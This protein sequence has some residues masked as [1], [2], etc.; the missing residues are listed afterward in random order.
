MASFA[1]QVHQES[2]WNASARSP[3]G[4][5]GLTQFMPATAQWI[6]GL[7]PDL[8]ER[9]PLNPTWALRAL[10]VYDQ[11]L[12]QRIRAEN[13]CERMAFVLSAY[14]GGLGWVYK[15]QKLSPQPG[16]CFDHT[17]AINP[18]VTP[19]SQAENAHYP[20]VILQTFE[21]LYSGWGAGSC[22]GAVL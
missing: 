17:C 13:D 3:V 1:A 16:L 14:N 15:R 10:V 8:A 6:G 2:R 7:S 22:T 4:A 21:P 20:A 18:G 12:W 19:A 11:W 9:A 5:I